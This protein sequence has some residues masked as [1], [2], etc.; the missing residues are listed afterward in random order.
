VRQCYDVNGLVVSVQSDAVSGFVARG[1][2]LSGF[3]ISPPN[4][5]ESQHQATGS[6][7]RP[8]SGTDG[9]REQPRFQPRSSPPGLGERSGE[10]APL[11]LLHGFTGDAATWDDVRAELGPDIPCI[12][13]DLVGHG[14]TEHPSGMDHYHMPAAVADLATL[15]DLLGLPRV[16]LLGYSMGGRTA[17]QFAVAHPERVSALLLESASPGI[18][19]PAERAARVQSDAA[20]A[21]RIER[22]GIPVFVREWE[23]LPLFRSQARLPAAIRE[24]QRAQRLGNSPQG[25]ANSLRGMGAGAQ[26]SLWPALAALSMPVLLITGEEDRKYV[27]LAAAMAEQLQDVRVFIVPEAGHTVHLEQP[28]VFTAAVGDFLHSAGPAKAGQEGS[29]S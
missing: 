18:A 1:V 15:L 16:A 13:V 3:A 29:R 8:W 17:L 9:P 19:D 10:R 23:A 26:S 2:P 27:G 14:E 6:S 12:A 20:L 11:L 7:S 4:L 21:E 25:M 28:A 24:A 5:G 22:D